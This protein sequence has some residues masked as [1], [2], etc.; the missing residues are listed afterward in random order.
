MQNLLNNRQKVF[1]REPKRF[2]DCAQNDSYFRSTSPE[3]ERRR[4]P[5]PTNL[6]WIPAFAGMTS[7][8][9]NVENDR[10]NDHFISFPRSCVGTINS[11][12]RDYAGQSGLL[13]VC[14]QW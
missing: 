9:T 7:G 1:S 5:H 10:G 12:E 13:E 2:C 3:V 6:E 8:V 14:R 11:S 4:T